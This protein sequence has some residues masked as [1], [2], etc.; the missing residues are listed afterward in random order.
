M[1]AWSARWV[2]ML[3]LGEIWDAAV[4]SHVRE[5]NRKIVTSA[6]NIGVLEICA[7]FW[8]YI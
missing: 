6:R 1:G 4:C 3:T 8:K 2:C 7:D 5:R